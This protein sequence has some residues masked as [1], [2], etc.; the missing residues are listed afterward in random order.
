MP[1]RVWYRRPTQFAFF[2]FLSVIGASAGRAQGC[3]Q[4]RDNVSQTPPG[5]QKS[6]RIAI[7]VM[8]SGALGVGSAATIALRRLR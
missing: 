2:M 1:L 7:A 6:Y 5:V 4:C 3:S 8:L